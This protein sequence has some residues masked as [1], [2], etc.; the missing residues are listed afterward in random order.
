MKIL[1]WK[2]MKKEV[3]EQI[4][5][6]KKK[7]TKGKKTKQVVETLNVVEQVVEWQV[8]TSLN[9]TWL[10]ITFKKVGGKLHANIQANYKVNPIGD[11]IIT[12]GCT[13]KA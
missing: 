2:A 7:K 12:F 1:W 8:V 6:A 10:T 11:A 13:T 3:V 4:K 9:R 5:E